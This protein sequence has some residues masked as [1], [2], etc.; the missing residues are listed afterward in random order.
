[1]PTAYA[2]MMIRDALIQGENLLSGLN[3]QLEV[4]EKEEYFSYS[5]YLSILDR[6]ANWNQQPDWGFSFGDRLGIASHGVL[7]FGAMSA[8]TVKDGLV[9]LAQY[10]STRSPLTYCDINMVHEAVHITFEVD[11]QQGIDPALDQGPGTMR[12][13]NPG[14]LFQSQRVCETLCMVFQ[15]Y[16]ESV[17]ASS[18]PTLWRFPYDEPENSHHYSRWIHGGYVFGVEKLMLEVPGS[19]AMVVSA[20]RND[21][22][23][24]SSIA[25]CEAILA[26][27]K[28]NETLVQVRNILNDAYQ[29]R[30]KQS[31]PDTR[32]PDADKVAQLMGISKRTLIRKLKAGNCTFQGIRDNLL[33]TQIL[34]LLQDP[35]MPFN[36]ISHRLGYQDAGNFSR[37]CR[38]LFGQSPSMLR[39]ELLIN[40]ANNNNAVGNADSHPVSAV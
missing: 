14:R 24:Q 33:K 30:L 39:E 23:Y 5:D 4:L 15:T 1:M 21:A 9:L 18:T 31:D 2:V 36:D 7:G 17:G 12:D 6:Y 13:Q 3:I 40:S 20:F 16:I 28:E 32:I 29:L 38:R 8:P 27:R 11:D 37:A 22:V 10:V 34:H 26:A 25:Q 35:Q 19:V